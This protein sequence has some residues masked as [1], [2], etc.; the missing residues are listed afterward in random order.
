[1]SFRL[2]AATAAF[3]LASPARAAAPSDWLERLAPTD[4]VALVRF[5]SAGALA[6]LANAIA[7]MQGDGAPKLPPAALL[8]QLSIPGD[9][10]HVATD[11]PFAIALRLDMGQAGPEPDVVYI[12]PVDDAGAFAMQNA[13]GWSFVAI[14][15]Y[16]AATHAAEV[17]ET[18]VASPL[19]KTLQ[20]GVASVSVDLKSLIAAYR[21]MIDQGL[22][23][24]EAL[25]PQ[26]AAAQQQT[27]MDTEALLETYLDGAR[28]V[29][30]SGEGF[31]LALRRD[32]SSLELAGAYT[33]LEKSPLAAFGGTKPADLFAYPGSIDPAAPFA[34]VMGCD[35]TS[36]MQRF[37]PMVDAAFDAYPD[38]LAGPLRGYME[39]LA[40][41]YPLMGHVVALSGEF[42]PSGMRARYS[43][44]C[45]K[46]SEL[47]DAFRKAVAGPE[48][49]KAGIVVEEVPP[50]SAGSVEA[51]RLRISIDPKLLE[52]LTGEAQ[53]GEAEA[54]QMREVFASIYGK[55]GL[56]LTLVPGAGSVTVIAGGDDAYV[57]TALA[58]ASAERTP[59]AFPAEL[60][61]ALGRANGG[62]PALVYHLDLGRLLH[63]VAGVMG[64]A[65]GAQA[66]QL[67]SMPDESLP[68]TWWA[69]IRGRRWESGV[70]T[71]LDRL[72]AFARAAE[73]GAGNEAGTSPQLR[74]ALE[75]RMKADILSIDS[76]LAE[77]AINNGGRYPDSLDV[78]IQ[79]DENGHRYLDRTTL[80][81]D[82]WKNE[83]F[84]VPPSPGEP[85]P[86]VYTLGKDGEVGG[87]G[88]DRDL[89]NWMIRDGGI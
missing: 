18:A 19:A 86:R 35:W 7:S 89:D 46:P 74:R 72:R 23:M 50:Y 41:M 14:E 15:G 82:P 20:T 16:V 78:L 30:D 49:A 79:P 68:L 57:R 29:I 61:A 59:Q 45:E 38:A 65:L 58:D 62:D 56:V 5:E 69:A 6:E 44:R 71:D 63:Q 12:V 64:P 33:A 39:G 9:L 31:E 76:A 80:P 66:E 3:A 10:S 54:Q 34:M 88:D 36:L 73:R 60:R 13:V 75:G 8:E 17:G 42:T 21:P 51:P 55:D 43:V 24:A 70:F 67:A 27:G 47:V 81:V 32:G 4:S 40:A 28:S 25:L 37:Q 1:M 85:R 48:L 2:A 84:Y 22:Q 11:R 52:Q 77:Y 83:Y 53:L 87:E 26:M